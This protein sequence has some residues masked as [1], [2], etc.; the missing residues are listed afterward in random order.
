VPAA[1]V[2]KKVGAPDAGVELWEYVGVRFVPG[3]NVLRLTAE[4]GGSPRGEARAV[5]VVPDRAGRIE[6]DAPH[7]VPA[8]GFTPAVIGLRVVDARGV[9]HSARTLVTVEAS[10]GRLVGDDVDPMTGGL[11]VALEGGTG[12]VTLYAQGQPGVA[13]VTVRGAGLEGHERITFVPDLRPFLA[14]GAIE[15]QVGL[16]R[17]IS[18]AGGET[19]P[20]PGPAFEHEIDRYRSVSSDGGQYAAVHGAL[21]MKGRVYEEL[22]LTVGYDSDRPNDLRRMRDIQPDAFYPIYGDASV[23]GYDA[24]S[25]ND[26]YARLDRRGTSLLYG[27]FVTP[28]AGGGRT[29]A[30]Y[31]RSLSGAYGKVEEAATAS[32]PGRAATA[33]AASSTR[34]PG[35]AS[36]ARTMSRSC[37]SSRTASGS[38]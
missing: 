37:R 28:G 18:G 32:M 15:A 11:Q 16:S 20:H 17:R 14:V 29:L 12:E 26:L 31:S 27:D 21:F 8:D 30:S 1:R 9:P 7:V 5:V 25:T 2:G 10:I 4:A 19:N 38:R 13:E 33:R 23:K 22:L 35:A 24:R 34:S 6:I 36:R 3:E